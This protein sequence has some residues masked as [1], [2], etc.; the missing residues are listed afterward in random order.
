MKIRDLEKAYS[1]DSETV[2][3]VLESIGLGGKKPNAK[4]S[5]KHLSD[6]EN[7]LIQAEE[8]EAEEVPEAEET[9]EEESPES[10]EEPNEF[11]SEKDHPGT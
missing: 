9:A 2:S 10:P 7:A 8:A 4:M 1:L 5:K 11:S 3:R 6:F